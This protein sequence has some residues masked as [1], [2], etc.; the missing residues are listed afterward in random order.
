MPWSFLLTLLWLQKYNTSHHTAPLG[1]P[2]CMTTRF[3]PVPLS[4]TS[5]TVTRQAPLSMGFPRQEYWGGLPCPPPGDLT[6]PEIES[7]SHV[8]RIGKRGPLQLASPGKALPSEYLLEFNLSLSRLIIVKFNAYLN[9]LESLPNDTGWGSVSFWVF[10]L[11]VLKFPFSKL[12]VG[13][14]ALGPGITLFK[15][16]V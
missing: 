8:F 9:H 11:L 4:V 5:W 3:G 15:S 16:L 7:E 1:V 6:D 10:D 2:A 14:G 13:D 12:L